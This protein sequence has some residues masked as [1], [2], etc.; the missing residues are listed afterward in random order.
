M[1]HIS[2]NLIFATA[3]SCILNNR[4]QWH[5]MGTL[6][7]QH[8]SPFYPMTWIAIIISRLCVILAWRQVFTHAPELKVGS[9]GE[10]HLPRHSISDTKCEWHAT[11]R[12]GNSRSCLLWS[13]QQIPWKAGECSTISSDS[14]LTLSEPLTLSALLESGAK[15]ALPLRTLQTHEHNQALEMFRWKLLL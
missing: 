11:V 13:P 9:Q 5:Q 8:F 7:R 4:Q 3:M 12:P 14:H 6:L 15:A 1:I 10:W 2:Y